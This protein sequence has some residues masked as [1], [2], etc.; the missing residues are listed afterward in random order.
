MP[1]ITFSVSQGL[2]DRIIARWG[3]VANYKVW[4]RATTKADIF[5]AAVNNA[6]IVAMAQ[7]AAA[8]VAAAAVDAGL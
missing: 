4:L 1:D 2:N 3:S 8:R 5:N 6:N 7:V